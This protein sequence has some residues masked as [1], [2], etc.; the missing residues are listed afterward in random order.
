MGEFVT[1]ATARERF[2]TLLDR[3]DA[4]YAEMTELPSDTVGS[5]FRMTVAERLETQERRNRALMYRCFGQIADPPDE[6]A[7]V[8]AAKPRLAARLRIPV[9]EVTRRFKLSAKLCPRRQITG[10]PLPPLLPEVA[11]A[12]ADGVLG[13]DHLKAI[14][15]TLDKLPSC[16]SAMDRADVESHSCS[17]IGQARCRIRHRDR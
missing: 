17:R 11:E 8:P 7:M 15:T 4:A 5:A 2:S 12:L 3:V 1:G 6:A 13:E 10:P 16:T 9:R 14:T